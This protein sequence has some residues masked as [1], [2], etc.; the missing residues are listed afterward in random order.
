[1]LAAAFVSFACMSFHSRISFCCVAVWLLSPLL[2]ASFLMSHFSAPFLLQCTC[3]LLKWNS[4]AR[5]AVSVPTTRAAVGCVALWRCIA[6]FGHPIVTRLVLFSLLCSLIS[7]VFWFSVHVLA[8]LAMHVLGGRSRRFV[9]IC[10]IAA[11]L[12]LSATRS[13][14]RALP[15]V[16]D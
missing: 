1:M 10:Q 3:A 13:V 6:A 9:P 8:I 14:G 12:C 15:R 2:S 7:S 11:L 4:Y 16:C 5:V